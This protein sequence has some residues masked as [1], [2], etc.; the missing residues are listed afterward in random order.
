MK[1][2]MFCCETLAPDWSHV[3]RVIVGSPASKLLL[4]ELEGSQDLCWGTLWGCAVCVYCVPLVPMGVLW[5]MHSLIFYFWCGHPAVCPWV[6]QVPSVQV[7]LHE[8]LAH[9]GGHIFAPLLGVRSVRYRDIS[10]TFCCSSLP[11]TSTAMGSSV[12][13]SCT[14]CSRRPACLSLATKWERSS[15]SSWLMVTRTKMGRLV[16]KSS[17]M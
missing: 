8:A 16:L 17:S 14:S 9:G 2:Q 1:I 5:T 12:T 15:R 11:Q 13:T 7:A 6:Q 3:P 4:P 10:K